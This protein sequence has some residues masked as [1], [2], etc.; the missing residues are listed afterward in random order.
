METDYNDQVIEDWKGKVTE[1]QLL[2]ALEYALSELKIDPKI[3]RK[4]Y[5]MRLENIITSD[6]YNPNTRTLKSA[7]RKNGRVTNDNWVNNIPSHCKLSCMMIID[8][9]F[10]MLE[11]GSGFDNLAEINHLRNRITQLFINLRGYNL[12]IEH[13]NKIKHYIY[14]TL[15]SYNEIDLMMKV[16]R[17]S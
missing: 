16:Q 13:Y 5:H 1:D 6:E 9:I 15:D 12:D 14:K 10:Q 8:D 17:F 7:R 4:A 3:S 11:D 2:D